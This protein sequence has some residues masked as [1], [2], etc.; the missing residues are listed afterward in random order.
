MFHVQLFGEV[1]KCFKT[2][3][4]DPLDKVPSVTKT[5]NRMLETIFTF[6]KEKS[7]HVW[8]GCGRS[9]MEIMESCYPDKKDPG[10]EGLVNIFVTPL[11]KFLQGGNNTMQQ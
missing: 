10:P 7:D 3:L 9:L 8:D 5:V 6:L 1:A 11:I 2:E 4:L